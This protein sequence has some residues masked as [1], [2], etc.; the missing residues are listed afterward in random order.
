MAVKP[1][2]RSQFDVDLPPVVAVTVS[3]SVTCFKVQINMKTFR[4]GLLIVHAE[5]MNV[6]YTKRFV[7]Q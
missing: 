6:N 2:P 5:G 4:V 7:K 3:D 1:I